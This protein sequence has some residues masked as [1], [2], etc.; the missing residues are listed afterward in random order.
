MINPIAA[1]SEAMLSAPP[2][3]ADD[4]QRR[5]PVNPIA[6]T[7]LCGV[8]RRGGM[9]ELEAALQGPGHR[10]FTFRRRIYAL[11]GY[12]V[13]R[14]VGL[15]AGLTSASALVLAWPEAPWV[16]AARALLNLR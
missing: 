5:S 4:Q 15:F 12:I 2:L 11:I 3:H 9:D 1:A 6:T 13:T 10:V 14:A 7:A 16:Q 8:D